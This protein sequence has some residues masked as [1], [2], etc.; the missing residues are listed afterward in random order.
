MH[1]FDDLK[2][3]PIFIPYVSVLL[4]SKSRE[5][6][7]FISCTYKNNN[8]TNPISHS[9]NDSNTFLAQIIPKLIKTG[10]A[11]AYSFQ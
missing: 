9:Y 10:Y 8:H 6:H 3:T 4:S 7:K 11:A 5:R 2:D 1:R